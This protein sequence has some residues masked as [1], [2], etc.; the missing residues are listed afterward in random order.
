MTH[1]LVRVRCNGYEF[2]MKKAF[3]NMSKFLSACFEGDETIVNL[4]VDPVDFAD[5]ISY[6]Q[7]GTIPRNRYIL[8]YLNVDTATTVTYYHHDHSPIVVTK[9]SAF[10][11][12]VSVKDVELYE[13]S[14]CNIKNRV[15]VKHYLTE[16]TEY[17]VDLDEVRT[18]SE[19]G[20]TQMKPDSDSM[21]NLFSWNGELF[22]HIWI[23]SET[24]RYHVVH[25]VVLH[26]D[27]T[28]TSVLK[29]RWAMHPNEVAHMN[30]VCVASSRYCRIEE[31]MFGGNRVPEFIYLVHATNGNVCR[32]SKIEA[33]NAVMPQKPKVEPHHS[34]CDSTDHYVRYTFSFQA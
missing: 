10:G 2:T 18:Y 28:Y 26:D 7:G 14:I 16:I 24:V 34:C 11:K 4:D 29:H 17:T 22:Y 1:D 27:S 8:D 3:A 31:N 33:D 6:M 23:G 19:R 32:V 25:H 5:A 15:F 13:E 9:T 30:Y 12:Q 20:P 21:F